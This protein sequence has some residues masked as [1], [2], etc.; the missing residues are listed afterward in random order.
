M[1]FVSVYVFFG[2]FIFFCWSLSVGK[3]R[4]KDLALC[5]CFSFS[6]SVAISTIWTIH[7]IMLEFN[8]RQLV[9]LQVMK[10]GKIVCIYRTTSHRLL[11]AIVFVICTIYAEVF[12]FNFYPYLL[13]YTF[14]PGTETISYNATWWLS[15]LCRNC[16]R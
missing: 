10:S 6:L 3:N 9:P 8:E 1:S 2:Y 12:C 4:R 5:L 13:L 15:R 11:S 14:N 7:F 16:S